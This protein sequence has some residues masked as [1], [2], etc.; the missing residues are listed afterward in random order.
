MRIRRS[1]APKNRHIR[2]TGSKSETNRV[3]LLRA[4]YPNLTLINDSNAHDVDMMKR[5]LQQL[6][7]TV[8]IHHAGTAM[9]FLT[10]YFATL[11]GASVTLTGSERMKQRPIQVLVEA[12]DALGAEV[13]YAESSGFPPLKIQGRRLRGGRLK[14]RADISSQ[15]LSALCLVAPK[16]SEGLELEFDGAL[17]SVPYLKMTL[18]LLESIGVQTFMDE[19]RVR[20]SPLERIK[21]QS[22]SVESDWSAASYYYSVIALSEEGAEVRLSVLKSDSL[23][24]DRVLADLYTA[25]GVETQF[26]TDGAIVLRK[27]RYVASDEAYV[28]DLKDAP[29]IAQTIAV[30]AAGLGVGCTMTGLHTLPIKETDRLAAMKNELEK[31]GL[32]VSITSNSLQVMPRTAE[33]VSASIATY[34]DHRMAMAFAPLAMCVPLEIQDP[35][36]V[37]KSYPDF[38]KDLILLGFD[39][40][41]KAD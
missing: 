17:T 1:E 11:E 27:M 40:S 25:F 8:D 24:G 36:V 14:I 35:I 13:S 5:G 41:L 38:W 18:K 39:C 28:F 10:A 31:C 34:N 29:D 6:Q 16:F 7:G 15:Y 20:I 4:L 26:E 37:E 23:Q 33:L 3:L 30:T 9:R 22:L 32:R 2:L 21:D 12:L 19:E